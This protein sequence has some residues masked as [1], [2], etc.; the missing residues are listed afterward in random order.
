MKNPAQRLVAAELTRR[1]RI[2]EAARW[3]M[4]PDPAA[5]QVLRRE[6]VLERFDAGAIEVQV[7]GGTWLRLAAGDAVLY[8]PGARC[9]ERLT[10][11]TCSSVFL[12]FRGPD[13]AIRSTLRMRS[14]VIRL[15]D[16]ANLLESVLVR[17]HET[18]NGG[19]SAELEGLG[20]AFQALALVLD[21]PA[22][23]VVR[24]IAEPGHGERDLVTAV[25]HYLRQHLGERVRVE[26]IAEQVGLSGSGLAHSYRR[27][28][29]RSPMAA[30]RAFRI[31]AA[32]GML[33]RGG[34]K[35]SAIAARTGFADAF[36]LSRTFRRLTGQSPREYR[37]AHR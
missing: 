5:A 11:R 36:H 33:S 27:L 37:A 8:A 24:P 20:C 3:R 28:T 13:A 15:D 12:R 16:R 29:S 34:M 10:S 17:A 35:L 14:N 31:E 6:W 18:L 23:A 2:A 4:P 32:K 26:D 22:D 30:L 9:T 1:L 25:N 19:L 7:D 21:A